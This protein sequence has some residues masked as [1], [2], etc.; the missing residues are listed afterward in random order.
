MIGSDASTAHSIDD[1][2]IS[3]SNCFEKFH[4]PAKPTGKKAEIQILLKFHFQV[5]Y[6]N[7]LNPIK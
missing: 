2:R 4:K 3:D 1:R 5:S 6:K 7:S